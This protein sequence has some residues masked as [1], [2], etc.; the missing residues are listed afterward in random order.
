MPH[1]SQRTTS[2]E[3]SDGSNSQ[4]SVPTTVPDSHP[5]D[6]AKTSLLASSRCPLRRAAPRAQNPAVAPKP[7]AAEI[8]TDCWADGS[9]SLSFFL[10]LLQRNPGVSPGPAGCP[11]LQAAVCPAHRSFLLPHHHLSVHL[12]FFRS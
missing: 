8:S 10:P 12:A 2:A 4:S 7:T 1:H 9:N 6:T 11:R 5:Q 3:G